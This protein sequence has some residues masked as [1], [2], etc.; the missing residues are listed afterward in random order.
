MTVHI[1]VVDD[2]QLI[3]ESLSGLFEDEGYLVSTAPSGEEAVARFR[4][5][6]VDCIFL[7]IWMPGID[8]LETMS[9]IMQQDPNVPV[10]IMSGHATIDTAVRATKQG[11]FDFIEKPFSTDKL[12][13]LLRN[14]IE[15][16]R[17]SLENTDLKFESQQSC[18]QLV[19]Q[20]KVIQD[21]RKM[22]NKVAQSDA[23]VLVLGEHGTGKSIAARMLHEGSKRKEKPFI[24]FSAAGV[25]RE[26]VESELFGH[27]KGAFAGALHGQ[28]GRL[29]A[30]HLGTTFF[31]EIS[32]LSLNIQANVLQVMQERRLRRLG[33]PQPVP[34]DVRIIAA[35]LFEPE[36]LLKDELLREDFYYRL[37]VL[38]I[39]MPSVRER[40]ED[41][42][43]L[44]SFLAEEQANA[45][46]GDHVAFSSDVVSLL[47]AY[48]WPGNVRE[49]RNYV[50]RCHILCA[51]QTLELDTMLPLDATQQ[52]LPTYTAVPDDS[53]LLDGFHDARKRFEKSYI[54]HH[55]EKNEWNVSK[56]ATD[57]G[58]ERSQL[59]RKIKA[60]DLTPPNK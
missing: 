6:P 9:R 21:V 28:R 7:D 15:K 20:S 29:E 53:V 43:A 17:L 39:H 16:R 47:Q 10:I 5:H 2:E 31:S 30:A 48:E 4:K 23:S 55:L 38:T 8:G 32:E 13:I 57:I 56:T 58:M 26:L 11:A 35:S 12:L 51:G 3:R 60:H 46:G 1:M 42:P 24:S 52:Q 37:N 34:C 36:I 49:L 33:N 41:I 25:A 50:E 40:S 44:L 22:I 59:H 27:E 54:I 45:L 19:G 14:A 18:P